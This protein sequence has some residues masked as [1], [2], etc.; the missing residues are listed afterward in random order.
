[1]G[2]LIVVQMVNDLQT[3]RVQSLSER[4]ANHSLTSIEL[5][6]VWG[7]VGA[8]LYGFARWG[9][10]REMKIQEQLPEETASE[11]NMGN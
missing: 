8:A 11:V 6:V 10:G 5:V 1:M 3:L 9:T 7:L 2:L 4:I